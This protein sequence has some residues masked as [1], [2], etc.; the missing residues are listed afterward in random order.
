MREGHTLPDGRGAKRQGFGSA[1]QAG[2]PSHEG[3]PSKKN[4]G[5]SL[6]CRSGRTFLSRQGPSNTSEI[7]YFQRE[8]N[9]HTLNTL[10]SQR[11]SGWVEGH[12]RNRSTKEHHGETGPQTGILF[13]EQVERTQTRRWLCGAYL[14]RDLLSQGNP[15]GHAFPL[16]MVKDP[17]LHQNLWREKQKFC[18]SWGL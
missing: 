7:R 2:R 10:S 5:R 6:V 1:L 9:E 18:F 15:S 16:L 8:N 11:Q 17:R 3:R 12:R 14:A 13:R 4:Q